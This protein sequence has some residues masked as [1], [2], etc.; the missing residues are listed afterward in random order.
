MGHHADATEHPEIHL[1]EEDG[2]VTPFIGDHQAMQ[3]WERELMMASADRLC[4]HGS[5][6]LEVGLGLGLSALHIATR[7]NTRRHVVVERYRRVIE[8]FGER[9]PELPATLQIVEAD[10]FDYVQR[11]APSS[12]DGIF[13][14]PWLPREVATDEALWLRVM[15]LVVRALR[16]GGA[17][18]PFFT[19]RPELKWP[20]YKF[21]DRVIVDKRPFSA[22]AST[23]YTNGTSGDAYIQC[24]VRSH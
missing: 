12:L 1:V 14:D 18:I 9:H 8:L 19:T 3:G 4:E 10:F 22:Y 7:A 13:F 24:F 23:E 5:E 2:E 15:P 6:F 21:F 20:F 17:F 16:P 11:L